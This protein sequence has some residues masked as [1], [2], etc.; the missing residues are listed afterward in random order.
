MRQDLGS[1]SRLFDL[2]AAVA[3]PVGSSS[4]AKTLYTRFPKENTDQVE[5]WIDELDIQLPPLM[6]FV[7]PSGGLSSLHLNHARTVCRRAER[8]VVPLTTGGTVDVECGRYLNR[9]SDLFFVCSRIA[10]SRE[11]TEEIIWRKAA[12]Q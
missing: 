1:K 12:P 6:N 10:A 8:S 2:G 4:T 3:T 7:I 5:S 9:L 11:K